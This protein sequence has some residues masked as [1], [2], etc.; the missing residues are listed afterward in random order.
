MEPPWM[1]LRFCGQEKTAERLLVISPPATLAGILNPES[2]RPQG[3]PKEQKSF[4]RISGYVEQN[5]IHSPQTTVREALV[6][7]ASLR[8]GPEVSR[9]RSEDFVD[10]VSCSYWVLRYHTFTCTWQ[11]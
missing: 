11:G 8:L 3:F 4:A 9:D 1:Y 7:S 2:L 10:E 5:D 6:Y